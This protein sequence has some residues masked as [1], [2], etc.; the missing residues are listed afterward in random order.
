MVPKDGYSKKK[1]TVWLFKVD[2]IGDL[3]K[4]IKRFVQIVKKNVRFLL[5]P[6]ETAPFT[7][8]NVIQSEKIAAA[9]RG[10]HSRRE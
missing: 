5:N 1:E 3:G 4:C 10:V 8:K 2:M 7:A 9:K 6:E